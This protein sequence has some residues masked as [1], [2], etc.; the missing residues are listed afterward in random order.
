MLPNEDLGM[1]L[2]CAV[3]Y[4]ETGRVPEEITNSD[5]LAIKLLFENFRVADDVN[6]KKFIARCETNK[7]NRNAYRDDMMADDD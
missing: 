5:N 2:K 1:L 7:K 4:M 6:F 3:G